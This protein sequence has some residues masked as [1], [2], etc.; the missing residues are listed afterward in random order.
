MKMKNVV[1]DTNVV[2]HV[3]VQ[4][5]LVPIRRYW[6]N[7]HWEF[8]FPFKD[9]SCGK[10]RFKCARTI[11]AARVASQQ[12]QNPVLSPAQVQ[13]TILQ[14]T[15]QRAVQ[16]ALGHLPKHPALTPVEQV[17]FGDVAGRFLLCKEQQLAAGEIRPAS[18]RDL[19]TR[20]EHLRKA[21][22]GILTSTLT[23]TVLDAAIRSLAA[24]SPRSVW[25]YNVTLKSILIW[26]KDRNMAPAN[27][28][29]ILKAMS[30]KGD[31][32]KDS[33]GIN[34]FTVEEV[35]ALLRACLKG[36]VRPRGFKLLA[37]VALEAFCGLRAQEAC[38]LDW[39]SVDL[40]AG[41]IRIKADGSKRKRNR[42]VT[43]PENAK[44]WLQLVP[45]QQRQGGGMPWSSVG[46]HAVGPGVRQG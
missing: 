15:V 7:D 43:I 5:K 33:E 27:I 17:T 16:D 10:R 11:E 46:F 26:A 12:L 14:Q 35:A 13:A 42:T 24:K 29:Q 41:L 19:L 31:A 9:P 32:R 30:A 36:R 28:L 25:N 2:E 4:G 34:P 37:V 44:A 23:V 38:S 20:T 3:A 1:D 45:N 8:R 6:L 18:Y 39:T 40:K 22:G 21:I